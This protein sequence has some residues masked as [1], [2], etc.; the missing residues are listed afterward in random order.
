MQFEHFD[1][2]RQL[3]NFRTLESISYLCQ[4]LVKT[5][6]SNMYPLVFR[7]V[8]L[9]LTLH[10]STATTER[11]FSAM[12]IFNIAL[13]NRM[14]DEFFNACLL[15]YVEKQITKHFGIDSII[16]VFHGMQ[17]RVLN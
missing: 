16:D 10:A 17:E 5:R 14:E 7:V 1:Y 13:H 4:W 6:E 11:S 2:V 12:K 3:S 9:I 15:V 8:T